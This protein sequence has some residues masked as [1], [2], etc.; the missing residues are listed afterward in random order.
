RCI[1]LGGTT[2]PINIRIIAAA[3]ADLRELI[4]RDMFRQDMFYRLS[5]V[6]I[7]LPPLREIPADIP[8]LFAHFVKEAAARHGLPATEITFADRK[9]LMRHHWPGNGH[10]LRQAALRRVIG[11][12]GSVAETIRAPGSTLKDR[13]LHFEAMEIARV[14]DQCKGNTARAAQELGIPRRTLTAKISRSPLRDPD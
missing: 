5:D 2:T 13:V 4:A 10:E 14:L 3:S 7:S 11:L 6:E 8:V 1:E 12:E 9:T